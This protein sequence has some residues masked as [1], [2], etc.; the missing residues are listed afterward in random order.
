MSRSRSS[1]RG[2][3][4]LNVTFFAL[5]FLLLAVRDGG[6]ERY[7]LA[8]GCPA[9]L[10]VSG[11]LFPGLFRIDKTLLALTNFISALGLLL[12]SLAF[13]DQLLSSLLLLAAGYA[14]LVLFL[15][16]GV[17]SPESPAVAG[18][19]ALL[20]LA[21]LALPFVF[22]LPVPVG[23]AA[24]VFLLLPL[25]VLLARRQLL[26]AA[27]LVAAAL[28]LLFLRGD[29]ASALGLALSAALLAWA[30]SGSWLVLLAAVGLSGGLGW[31]ALRFLPAL[32][33][34]VLP[35]L[36]AR[37][38]AVAFSGGLFGT[39][40]GLGSSVDLSEN[41][42]VLPLCLTAEQF[43]SVFLCCLVLVAAALLLRGVSVAA[44]SR[45]NVSALQGMGA[46]ILLACRALASL[47]ALLG[48]LPLPAAG[49]PFLSPDPL[50]R[51][52]AFA[53]VGWLAGIHAA[54]QSD[55]KEDTHLAMLAR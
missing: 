14:C 15:G 55:L 42:S 21:G 50:S 31:A 20:A 9:F 19:F 11:L 16:L 26:P 7:L 52:A 38:Q 25:S 5:A 49:F 45:R 3:T 10:L 22:P 47:C 33:P 51:L 4:A 17:A 41:A 39:G 54:N 13:P 8:A 27:L 48:W 46:V 40:L 37:N 53:L 35:W 24:C 44:A 2:L 23:P 34:G 36:S 6:T 30:S 29:W 12:T 28:C 1:A 43:G 32:S 18:L